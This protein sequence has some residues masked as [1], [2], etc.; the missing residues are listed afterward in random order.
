MFRGLHSI[1]GLLAAVLVTV[2]ALTGVILSI[3]PV[4]ER[5]STSVPSAGELSVAAVAQAMTATYPTIDRIVRRASGSLM[6]HYA[7][8]DEALAVRVDPHDGH[9]L[10]AHDVSGVTQFATEL[11]RSFMLDEAGR[12]IAGGSALIL[13]LLSITG[14]IMLAR[15]LGGWPSILRPVRGSSTQRVHGTVARL[16]L[17]P[18]LLSAITGC[19]MSMA[20]FGIVPDNAATGQSE[21]L[22]SSPGRRLAVNR[23][24]ALVD[25][26]L[27]DLRELTFPRVNEPRSVYAVITSAGT[28]QI[29]A[30]TGKMLVFTPH[31]TA[32]RIYE[33][34]YLLHTGQGLW[35]LAIVCG[36]A[37]LMV[38]LLVGAGLL[39]WWKRIRSKPRIRQNASAQTA[40]TIIL[41]GSEGNSTWAFAQALHAAMTKVGHRVHTAPMNAVSPKYKRAER[42]VILAATYGDG[43]P[44]ASANRFLQRL[45]RRHKPYPVAVVGFGDR[46][47][48]QFC[49]FADD[50]TKALQAKGWPV[51]VPVARINRQSGQE[52]ARWAQSFG[53]ALGTPLDI[54]VVQVVPKTKKFALIERV[55]YGGEVQAPTTVLR[56]AVDAKAKRQQRFEVGDLIGILPPGADAPRLYSLASSTSDGV[57]EICVRRQTG[58]ICSSF[59]YDLKIG[60]T[61]DAFIRPNPAFRPIRGKSPLLLIGA[62]TGI[63]PLAGFIRQNAKHRPIH[64]YWGGRHPSSDFLYQRELEHY[65]TDSRLKRCRTAFSRV[66]GGFYVQDRLAAEASVV[67]DLVERGGQV[68]VCGGRA[69][70]NDVAYVVNLA[71]QPLGMNLKQLKSEGRYLED[72]Y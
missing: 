59:L 19:Y 35:P 46:G 32:R 70:A 42:M 53:M 49:R 62:G 14:T 30:N 72:V 15:S 3:E 44:P 29:D 17:L 38:P 55:D 67:R 16:V 34:V 2:L 23:V 22:G 28:G 37:A 36:L 18:L 24:S 39:I 11:H 9:E 60:S 57:L 31:S 20:T 50:V 65:L 56:F 41:V 54:A 10:A 26:D 7:R 71:I 12:A 69:M 1:G 47:F 21:P 33:F 61:I 5:L 52:F 48:P 27:S 63:G 13:V 8:G 25:I 51:L 40:D 58:G 43:A 64:L 45:A 66:E 6:V 68:M 4:R